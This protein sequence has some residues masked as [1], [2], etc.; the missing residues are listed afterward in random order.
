M[1]VC[2]CRA[3]YRPIGG[4]GG[5]GGAKI[6]KVTPKNVSHNRGHRLVEQFLQEEGQA[7]QSDE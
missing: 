3:G 1:C 7:A 4:E 5:G 2:M 6:K